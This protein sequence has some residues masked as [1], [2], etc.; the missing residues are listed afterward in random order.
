MKK[1][2]ILLVTVGIVLVA[3]AFGYHNVNAEYPRAVIKEAAP[4]ETLEYQEGVLI[5]ADK[6]EILSEEETNKI[7]DAADIEPIADSRIFN[8]TVTLTNTT[9]ET[10]ELSMTD[11]NLI[12][13]GMAN[14]IAKSIIDSSDDF[15]GQL[16]Q[17][18]SPGETKQVTYP[19]LMS[20]L[21]FAKKDWKQIEEQEFWLSFSEYPVKTILRLE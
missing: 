11:L 19:S 3:T 8:F 2:I 18:L 14:G 7:L 10:Q 20:S 12:T 6:I 5:S 9:Q 4:G 1:I 17:V 21:W 16:T 13:S 15:Y